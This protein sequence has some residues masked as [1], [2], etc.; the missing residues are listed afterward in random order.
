MQAGEAAK[1]QANYNA[2]VDRNNAILAN[3]AA[4]DARQRG[5]VAAATAAQQGN[6]LIGR[7]KAILASNGVVVNEGSALDL[8]SNTA[9]Q[10]K[11]D[12]LTIRNNAEREALGFEA[13]GMNYTS[14][15]GLDL[16]AGNNAE[17]AANTAAFSTALGGAGTVASR[18]YEFSKVSKPPA[19]DPS[20]GGVGAQPY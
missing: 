7:Q 13:Q 11:L 9:A 15:S 17:S 19:I 12:E 8:T 18:W 16:A 10:N 20:F 2:A 3:R 6:Q 4:A 1:A 14:Q 5:E